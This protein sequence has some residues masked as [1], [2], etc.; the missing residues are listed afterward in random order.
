MS[1]SD[2]SGLLEQG[3]HEGVGEVQSTNWEQEKADVG[4][5]GIHKILCP[6][7]IYFLGPTGFALGKYPA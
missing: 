2:N 1:H 7:L 6:D 3:G 4:G 5:N